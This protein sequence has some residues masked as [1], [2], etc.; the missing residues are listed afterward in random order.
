MAA[1]AR[2]ATP[3]DVYVWHRVRVRVPDLELM[4]PAAAVADPA[5]ACHHVCAIVDAIR[6]GHMAQ[7]GGR[8]HRITI[9]VRHSRRSVGTERTKVVLRNHV[10]GVRRS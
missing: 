9:L 2:V 5:L 7:Y 6:P 8:G 1:V 4:R 3:I 10:L